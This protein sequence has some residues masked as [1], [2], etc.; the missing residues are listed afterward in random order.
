MDSFIEN[1]FSPY[2]CG[3][4]KNHNALLAFDFR[5]WSKTGEKQLMVKK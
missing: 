4:R 1:K 2:L 5:F 3:F